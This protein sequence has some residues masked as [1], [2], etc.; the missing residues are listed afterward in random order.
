[1]PVYEYKCQDHG[2]FYELAT[3]DESQA[4]KPC[5]H[6]GAQSARI[7]RL[8]PEIL[9]MS[10]IARKAEQ[11]NERSSNEPVFSNKDRR[12]NDHEHSKGCGCQGGKKSKLMYTAQ[13]D[14]MFPSM[15]P[16]MISH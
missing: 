13:G 9:D 11:T 6:C 4:P 16:W 8:A 2:V 1:M 5:P 12:E 14:K 15:R 3:M 10:P 7:I